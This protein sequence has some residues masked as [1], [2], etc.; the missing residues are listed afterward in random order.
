MD[1]HLLIPDLYLH[2]AIHGYHT[3]YAGI[4]LHGTVT[5]D[6]GLHIAID[7]WH[8]NASLAAQSLFVAY[9]EGLYQNKYGHLLFT[10]LLRFPL[11]FRRL[12][13]QVICHLLLFL[14][15]CCTSWDSHLSDRGKI[16]HERIY[17]K[18]ASFHELKK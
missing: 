8:H 4:G 5:S 14:T 16:G 3:P 11:R 9:L 15:L 17:A 12:L 10:L 18:H 6:R 13:P 7:R 1:N 2:P